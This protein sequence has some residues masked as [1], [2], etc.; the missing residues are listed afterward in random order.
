MGPMALGFAK[1]VILIS[2][3]TGAEI[4]L[5]APDESQNLADEINRDYQDMEREEAEANGDL[6]PPPPPGNFRSRFRR[7]AEG[8]NDNY[9]Q[10]QAEPPPSFSRGGSG[11]T[12]NPRFGET[13]GK[14]EFILVSPDEEPKNPR[15]ATYERYRKYRR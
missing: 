5:S 9:D 6:A 13:K 7:D 2:L 12:P 15:A 11:G 8:N 1:L 10:R 4:A 3:L 14:I